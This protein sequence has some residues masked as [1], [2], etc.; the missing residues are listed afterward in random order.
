MERKKNVKTFRVQTPTYL[1][2]TVRFGFLRKCGNGENNR[3]QIS[4]EMSTH[5][6]KFQLS[7]GKRVFLFFGN[8]CRP[9]IEAFC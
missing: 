5:G 7:I 8:F 1:T 2:L 3:V 9:L 4:D 6:M